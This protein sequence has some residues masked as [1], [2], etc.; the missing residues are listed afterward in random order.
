MSTPYST[1]PSHHFWK[2]I[3]GPDVRV[4][5]Y[6]NLYQKKF[7]LG[8]DKG[9]RIATAGSCF[10]QNV[11][12]ELIARNCNF[13]DAEPA[14]TMLGAANRRR[15]GFDLFSA[16]YGNLYSAAQLRQLAERAFGSGLGAGAFWER[17]GRFY[18]PYRPSVEPDGFASVDEMLLSRDHHLRAVRRVFAEADVLIFT[19]GLTESWV[20]REDGSVYPLCPGVLAGEFEPD[21]YQLMNYRVGD[22][23]RDFTA[24]LDL[25]RPVNP[26][27]KV[28]LSV[29][30]QP[31]A[32]TATRHHAALADSYTK[33][34]L[35]SAVGE[36]SEDNANIDYF[37]AYEIFTSPAFG[38]QSYEADRRTASRAAIDMVMNLFFLVHG[39]GYVPPM[40]EDT[41]IVA[42]RRAAAEA[43]A[44]QY[45]ICDD[46]LLEAENA[47]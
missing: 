17:G 5:D 34:T 28:V 43:E 13:L 8:F 1:M 32:A 42:A 19:F 38:M 23:V 44:R 14:P 22:I 24:F 45:E 46:I 26:D 16:R 37:P 33:S 25:I 4:D 47:G 30:P 35:R 20:S 12:R 10:A 36:L 39:E 21:R 3:A 7:D 11:R 18:D 9:T 31:L 6:S 27:M 29:S 15:F 40:R 2:N 41:E